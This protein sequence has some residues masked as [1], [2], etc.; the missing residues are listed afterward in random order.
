M[1]WVIRNFIGMK[2]KDTQE[3]LRE[4][5]TQKR[6]NSWEIVFLQHWSSSR[7]RHLV[8]QTKTMGHLWFSS[9]G[10]SGAGWGGPGGRPAS[11]RSSWTGMKF[12]SPSFWWTRS[13]WSQLILGTRVGE[14]SRETWTQESTR[15]GGYCWRAVVVAVVDCGCLLRLKL[16]LHK[17]AFYE[18]L[19]CPV[20]TA[21][22]AEHRTVGARKDR[23]IVARDSTLAS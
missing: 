3:M 4:K 23:K 12:E 19:F 5:K 8:R 15:T 18:S 2:N 16:I 13:S 21:Q 9:W 17:G 1:K 6:W 11:W 20:S 10:R 14:T 22:V 7:E